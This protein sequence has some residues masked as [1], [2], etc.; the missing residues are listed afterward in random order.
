[1]LES[2]LALT[3][4][5]SL[6]LYRRLRDWM[7]NPLGVLRSPLSNIRAVCGDIVT[8]MPP[9]SKCRLNESADSASFA[10]AV[11]KSAPNRIR[12]I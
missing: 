10:A 1:M 11:P 7:A 9:G 2:V 4:S 12:M 3:R 5:N 8:L 6:T